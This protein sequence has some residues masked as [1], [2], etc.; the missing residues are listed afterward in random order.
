MHRFFSFSTTTLLL[1]T[2]LLSVAPS[3]AHAD[4]TGF[5]EKRHEEVNRLLKKPAKGP[6][7]TAKRDEKITKIIAEL[8][9]YDT[10]SKN[11]LVD[12]WDDKSEKE[13]TEFVSLLR[14]LVERNY[15]SNLENTL[16]FQIE[17]GKETKKDDAVLVATTARSK[18]NKRAPAVR[19]DYLVE[20]RGNDW[21]VTDVITDGVS[22][23]RNYR[24]QFNR[25][26]RKDGWDGLI[27]RMRTKLNEKEG[28]L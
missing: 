16:E 3:W 25:I 22:M 19:I 5:L 15:R 1:V 24:N 6:E 8:L 10:L 26:I 11:A 12:H 2:A 13:R 28:V 4:A 9:D 17:Y 23:V 14:Q 18:T 20:S 21:A 7:A 27:E